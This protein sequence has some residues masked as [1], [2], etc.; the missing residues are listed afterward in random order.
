MRFCKFNWFATY[1]RIAAGIASL[2][3]SVIL[4]S[5]GASD[6][7]TKSD[8]RVATRAVSGT[9]RDAAANR[10]ITVGTAANTNN[11]NDSEY[12]TVLADEFSQL[13]PEWE[14]KFAAVHPRPNTDPLPYD[15]SL[16]DGLVDYALAH[17]MQVRGHTLLWH[18]AVPDWLKNGRYNQAQLAAIAQDHITTVLQHFGT[19]IY[20]WDVVN[21]AFNDDGSMRSTIWFNQPGIGYAGRG[22]KY[23][24]QAL[25]WARAANPEIKLFYND[26]GADTVNRKSNA[27]YAMAADFKRR[28]V[29]LDG[30]GFQMHLDLSE[31]TDAWAA[32]VERNLKR[33]SDL[34]IEIH[35]TELDIRLRGDAENNL[36]AQAE[37]YARVAKLCMANANCKVL[38]T[39]G[40]T[41]KYS[42]IS[43]FYRG[44]GWALPWG[45]GYGKKPAYYALHQTFTE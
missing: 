8:F 19:N 30:I 22:T 39:W 29:P 45:A 43:G 44:M 4:G 20:A 38:Q 40:F 36:N 34:G 2:C 37:L 13:E 6:I 42:W 14:M 21:E 10:G 28:G 26:Y 31:N 7:S 16:S 25:V 27:I 41:D 15:F 17:H 5:C 18:E 11:L 35:I 1:L 32:S 24:E 12:S 9:L 23:I 3:V 33:F